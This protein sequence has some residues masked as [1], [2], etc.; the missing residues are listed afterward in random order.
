M[1]SALV[2]A[3]DEQSAYI[4]NSWAKTPLVL[5]N[6]GGQKIVQQDGF[7]LYLLEVN[8]KTAILTDIDNP[9]QQFRFE[10]GEQ[11]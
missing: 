11:Q 4:E 5:K 1:S 8:G 10:K 2:I 3:D 6:Q 7:D 9:K